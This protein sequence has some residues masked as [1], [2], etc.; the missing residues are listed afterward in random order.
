MGYHLNEQ[1]LLE[2]ILDERSLAQES[3]VPRY[4]NERILGK[5]NMIFKD[6]PRN[7]RIKV[8]LLIKIMKTSRKNY[9]KRIGN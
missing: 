7:K 6:F 8:S 2:R 9:K 5:Q 3:I 1:I 4:L